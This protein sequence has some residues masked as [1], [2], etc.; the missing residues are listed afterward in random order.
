MK[1]PRSWLS[2]EMITLGIKLAPDEKVRRWL[3]IGMEVAAEGM[4][5]ELPTD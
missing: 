5:D 1:A 2:S 3:V 4:L